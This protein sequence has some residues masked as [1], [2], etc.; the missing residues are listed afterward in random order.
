MSSDA[1]IQRALGAYSDLS[2]AATVAQISGGLINQSFSVSDGGVEYI[3]QCVNQSFRPEIHENIAA[4]TAHLAQKGVPSPRLLQTREGKRFADLGPQGRW[5]LMTRLPGRSLDTCTSRAMARSAGALVATFHSALTDLDHVFEPLGFP[6][7]DTPSHLAQLKAA[8]SQHREHPLHETVGQL[9]AQVV[10]AF[11]DCHDFRRLP[12][13]PIHGD[14][15]FN[16]F[17]F[18][19]QEASALVDLDSLGRLPLA[20][21]LG[22]AWRSWCN[23]AGEDSCEAEFDLGI[24]SSAVEG[25]LGATSLEIS[26]E[27]RESLVVAIEA[28]S[29][30]LAARFAADALQ[31]SYFGWD[32]E[33]FATAGEHN[34]LRARGQFSL[35]TQAKETRAQQHQILGA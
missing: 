11:D 20:Y 29:L 35:Y 6:F 12:G 3:L 31:E 15:K 23:R 18:V 5:R 17:L 7:H 4:V 9:A 26:A 21:D 1:V 16:N 10:A 8:V 25:Y 34:L 28:I 2:S 13:R 32:P 24:F 30:E 14:L 27:E 33:R 22:D 19:D